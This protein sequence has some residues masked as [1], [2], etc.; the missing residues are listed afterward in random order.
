MTAK[1]E[2]EEINSNIIVEI[3]IKITGNKAVNKLIFKPG[4]S[5]SEKTFF[6]INSFKGLAFTL[7]K[8]FVKIGP[9]II[10]V[11]IETIIP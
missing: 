10:I 8:K 4:N 11:G 6:A 5:S 7:L 3:P 1:T 2:N 9:E